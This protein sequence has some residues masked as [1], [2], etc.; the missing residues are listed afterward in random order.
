M[1]N[2]QENFI[3]GITI[4]IL[5]AILIII[6]F[7]LQLSIG[8]IATTIQ[9]ELFLNSFELSLLS[10]S[11]YIIYIILQTPGGMLIDKF[12]VKYLLSIGAIVCSIG[13]IIFS[14]TTKIELAIIGRILMGGGSSFAFISSI[15]II[16]KYFP[17]T[18]F[19]FMV[20]LTETIAMT[21][22]I[23][24]NLILAKLVNSIGWRNCF[25]LTGLF[26]AL[27]SIMI[28]ILIKESTNENKQNIKLLELT[29]IIKQSFKKKTII[30]I[31]LYAGSCYTIS[32]VFGALW[33][34]QFFINVHNI[35]HYSATIACSLIYLGMGLSSPYLSWKYNSHKK[36]ENFLKLNSIMICMLMFYILFKIKLSIYS[37]YLLSFILGWLCGGMILAYTIASETAPKEIKN[38]SIG[39]IN[40]LALI[41][42]P[43]FQGIIGFTMNI[44][45]LENF[46]NNNTEVMI[47]NF[48][49][50]LSILPILILFSSFLINFISN[51][52]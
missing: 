12:G 29:K 47:K 39:I 28:W 10:S 20:G 36:R 25:F 48:Q 4:W 50:S 45:I 27:L 49:I 23:V 3:Y 41:T 13:C 18:Y 7:F 34:I 33:G 16:A 19:N 11:Y 8:V 52:K 51:K 38:T 6:Q 43:I 42:A 37:I 14:L 46:I 31:G 24:G 40:T 15:N 35:D 9:D 22:A 17:K 2:K 30:L 5:T 32:T 1:T 26:V 44:K 21:G